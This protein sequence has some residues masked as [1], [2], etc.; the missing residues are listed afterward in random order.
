MEGATTTSKRS[1]PRIFQACTRC[2]AGKIRCD[3]RTPTCTPCGD[4]DHDCIYPEARRMRG[5]GKSKQRFEALEGRL[6]AMEFRLQ[7]PEAGTPHTSPETAPRSD[8]STPP[9]P[10]AT[11]MLPSFHRISNRFARWQQE[12]PTKPLKRLVLSPLTPEISELWLVEESL[13]DCCAELPFFQIPWFL[14]RLKRPDA[15]TSPDAWWQGLLHAT[16]ANGVLFKIHTSSFRE[17]APYAWAFLKKAYAVLPEL[18]IH[19]DNLAA[20]QAVMSMALFMRQSGDTRTTSRLLSIAVRMY[21]SATIRLEAGEK[22]A[23]SSTEQENRSR[24]FWATFILDVE[25]SLS[26]GLPP[27]CPEYAALSAPA[28]PSASD[29]HS[30]IFNLGA[31]LSQIQ[32]RITTH[33]LTNRQSDLHPLT[34]ELETWRLRIPPHLRPDLHH[35]PPTTCESHPLATLHL[36]Y[37]ST[38]CKLSWT[39]IQHLTS[40]SQP[41]DSQKSLAR[42]SARSILSLSISLP[43]NTPFTHLY[44][45]LSHPLSACIVLLAVICKEPAHPEAPSDTSLLSQFIQFLSCLI[46]EGCDLHKLRDGISRFEQVAKDAVEAALGSNMPVNPALWPLSLASGQTGKAIA[47]LLTCE[48]YQ[49]MYLAQSFL[50]NMPNRDTENA[51]RFAEILGLQWADNNGYGAFVPESLMPATYGFVFGNG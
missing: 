31:S 47:T 33:L 2:R 23:L 43:L 17:V 50:G 29:Q 49:P 26:T 20:A 34:A 51:K 14:D 22:N 28:P 7:Q 4:R 10:A 37:F 46:S 38:L 39:V 6:A 8:K 41:S 21:Q 42:S 18:I 48:A 45:I 15:I 35:P 24:F 11:G 40:L 27:T 44:T 32:H 5:P 30:I 36:S 16:I 9:P 25:T 3:A 13:E 12:A 1:R 19:G